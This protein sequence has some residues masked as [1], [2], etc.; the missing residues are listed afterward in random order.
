M[1]RGMA[2]VATADNPSAIYFNPAGITQLEG[3]NLRVGLYAIEL[4]PSY[5]APNSSTSYENQ[6]K[7]HA[8]PQLYYTYTPK[9]SPLTLGLGAYS[10]FGLG[11]EWPQNSGLR[12]VALESSLNDYT[13]NP[14]VAWQLPWHLSVAAGLT[15][16]YSEIDLQQGLSAIPNND[17]LRFKGDAWALGYN[18]GTRW[19]PLEQLAFGV[20]FRSSSEMDY[21][22]HVETQSSSNPVDP[23]NYSSA[24]MNYP[25]PLELTAGVSYRPT[26]K[27]NLEFDAQFS[28]WSEVGNLTIHQ[29]PAATSLVPYPSI[30][31]AL[32][33]Q[34][35]WYYEW[36]VTR[37]FDNGW[38][39]SAGYIFNENSMGD[40]HY[41]PLITD[42]DRHF[43][44]VGTGY[45]GKH[46]DFDIAY[47]FGY[48]PD[49]TVVGSVNPAADGTYSFLSQAIA[50]SVGW[51][52]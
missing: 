21:S 4:D 44:S 42:L 34:S 14:V 26:K 39:V 41:S 13:I 29:T 22:G 47:Q 20:S 16:S 35:S 2:V 40:A 10:P 27:W 11:L 7:Y 45:R 43:F 17:V 12:S 49:R 32:D 30:P 5:R 38:H 15:V 28:D 31:V 23:A 46:L 19:Q 50:L 51:H 24:G 1:G 3:S 33:L 6:W 25:F 18:L 48:G 36:G 8:V 37:Y 52:F 9:D